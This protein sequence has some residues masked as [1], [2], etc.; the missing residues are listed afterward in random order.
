MELASAG[1]RQV[2]NKYVKKIIFDAD[3][4]FEGIFGDVLHS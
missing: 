3:T 1:R 2:A 4:F